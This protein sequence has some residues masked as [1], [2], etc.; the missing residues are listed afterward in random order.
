M[1]KLSILAIGAL[2]APG[3]LAA[4]LAFEA[5][6]VTVT[7]EPGASEVPVYF[8]FVNE[9]DEPVT[10]LGMDTTCGCTTSELE[11]L[12]Y[13]PGESGRIE[14]VLKAGPRSGVQ[15]QHVRVR[16]DNPRAPEHH[17]TLRVQIPELIEL[18]GRMLYWR[19]G[20]DP[21]P[22]SVRVRVA[23]SEPIH[24]TEVLTPPR[25]DFTV[26]LKEVEKGRAYELIATPNS[27][28][29]RSATSVMLVTDFPSEQPRRL[30]LS[31]RVY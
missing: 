24:I 3:L 12:H 31:L 8:P 11:K 27:T 15:Q 28:E 6:S 21:D 26:E 25:S 30:P 2:L 1:K 23:H 4:Q 29:S 22:K 16:T 19:V 7:A 5:H 17:L 14:A 13:E 10:I 20:D 9:G 18:S